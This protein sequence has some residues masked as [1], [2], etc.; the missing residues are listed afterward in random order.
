VAFNIPYV[1]DFITILCGQQTAVTQD[2]DDA[3]VRIEG[4]GEA[5]HRRCTRF[6]LDG[7]QAYD[8]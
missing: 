8:R 1:P 7:N 4:Q 3:N 6:K 5:T 2:H